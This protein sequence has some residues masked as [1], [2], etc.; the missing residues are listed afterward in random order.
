MKYG[1]TGHETE[2]TKMDTLCSILLLKNKTSTENREKI[3]NAV[4]QKKQSTYKGKPI[5]I[6]AQFLNR[7]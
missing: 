5:N 6:T 2:L 7:A 1:K 3:L 4:R